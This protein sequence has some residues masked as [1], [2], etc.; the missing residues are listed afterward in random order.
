MARPLEGKVRILEDRVCEEVFLG[1]PKNLS[2]SFVCAGNFRDNVNSC[3]G[4]SGGPMACQIKGKRKNTKALYGIVSTGFSCAPGRSPDNLTRVTK[5]LRWI[6]DK[7]FG[8][9]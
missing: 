6:H 7:I 1:G 3:R 4:D 2:S 5:Y 8:T 9:A